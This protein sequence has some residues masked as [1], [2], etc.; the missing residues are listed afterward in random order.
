MCII[1]DKTMVIVEDDIL[2]SIIEHIQN[3]KYKKE[4]LEKQ[5]CR[6]D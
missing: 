1:N 3:K 4:H 6:I 5:K 2:L